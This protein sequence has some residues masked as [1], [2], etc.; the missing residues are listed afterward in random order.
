MKHNN[1]QLFY[2]VLLLV[3][4][5][6]SSYYMMNIENFQ[7]PEPVGNTLYTLLNLPSWLI[8]VI[9]GMILLLTFFS[10]VYPWVVGLKTAGQGISTAG[11]LGSKWIN[12]AYGKRTTTVGNTL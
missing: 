8:Y 4:V 10:T 6:I 12:A 9:I 2:T 3:A 11:N 1:K 5:G 7:T